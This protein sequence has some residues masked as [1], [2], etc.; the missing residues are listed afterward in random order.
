[1]FCVMRGKLVLFK[2]GSLTSFVAGQFYS[3]SFE[4]RPGHYYKKDFTKG[5]FKASRCP[6]RLVVTT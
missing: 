5:H 2:V 1:M 3:S 6:L 4:G